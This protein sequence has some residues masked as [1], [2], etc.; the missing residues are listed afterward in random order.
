MT[1]RILRGVKRTS[2][3]FL[4]LFHMP[5]SIDDLYPISHEYNTICSHFSAIHNTTSPN[6]LRLFLILMTILTCRNSNF[7]SCFSGK[8][9][10]M[11]ANEWR[12]ALLLNGS[13]FRI[14]RSYSD[15]IRFLFSFTTSL[16]R[17]DAD[18][19]EM[20][21]EGE[22]NPKC[23]D[24]KSGWR[25]G[26]KQ[27]NV[28]WRERKWNQKKV[29]KSFVGETSTVLSEEAY[30]KSINVEYS[31]DSGVVTSLC[32][33]M[34]H[35]GD[36]FSLH[37]LVVVRSMEREKFFFGEKAE[38]EQK[39]NPNMYLSSVS[40]SFCYCYCNIKPDKYISIHHQFDI[41]SYSLS[42]TIPPCTTGSIRSH[43]KMRNDWLIFLSSKKFPNFLIYT[44]RHRS[45]FT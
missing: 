32:C 1:M 39:L 37:P 36:F 41:H 42:E 3:R 24:G 15:T 34:I 43:F 31:A 26:E 22:E 17:P 33:L 25:E 14:I 7:I 12:T 18:D 10:W 21:I 23:P 40:V 30:E 20:L 28:K 44:F 5:T 11:K 9:G 8:I 2:A 19:V 27:A 16:S 4:F 38:W 6:A 45:N 35:L 29:R 13:K